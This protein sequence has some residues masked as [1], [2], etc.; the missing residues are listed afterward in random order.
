MIE[1]CC[2][3]VDQTP[4]RETKLKLID[5]LRTV[6]EGKVTTVNVHVH[7]YYVITVCC[8]CQR[9]IKLY[10]NKNIHMYKYIV[11][12][13]KPGLHLETHTRGGPNQKIHVQ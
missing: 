3:F 12:E 8:Y 4:D 9:V 5:T 6:T 2:K 1:E 11:L 10:L 7:V 13:Y